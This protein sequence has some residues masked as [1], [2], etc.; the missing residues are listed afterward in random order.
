[1]MKII[2]VTGSIGMGKSTITR[3]FQRRGIKIISADALVH[4]LMKKNGA[5]YADV[6]HIFPEAL[7]KNEN[8]DRKTLG[9]L[10]FDDP[11]KRK[12]LEAI[13]HPLVKQAEADYASHALR[14]GARLV[15][16]DI[17]LLFETHADERLDAVVVASAPKFLQR[18]RVLKRPNMTQKRFE[19]IVSLQMPDRDKRYFADCVI[20]T[21]LGKAHSMRQ[22]NNYLRTEGIV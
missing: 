6:T 5:A 11:L 2:G 9:A 22:I 21:G 14:M 12:M 17:P 1:M 15:V 13:I 8:I 4:K 20:S 18:Q 19:H 10:V 16:L 3:M 7:D